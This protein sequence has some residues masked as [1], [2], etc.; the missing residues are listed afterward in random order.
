MFLRK[1]F[2]YGKSK[3]SAVW[4]QYI[5]ITLKLA[6]QN[7]RLLIQRYAKVWVF[8]KWSGNS[9]S[10]TFYVG[11][12][13]K[14]IS[15]ALFYNWPNFI[16]WFPKLFEILA[17]MSIL[18]KPGTPEDGTTECG[19]PAEQ[20]NT[21]E[22]WRNN[23]TLP[24]TPAEHPGTTEPYKTKNICSVFKRKFKTQNLNFQLKVKTFLLLI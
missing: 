3:L 2:V 19:T 8:R 12:F 21:P 1:S 18:W 15:H 13:N 14:N 20:Q 9:F 23:W 10:T 16:V 6:K 24:G 17:Y 5:S 7:F 11:I 4:F 22:E